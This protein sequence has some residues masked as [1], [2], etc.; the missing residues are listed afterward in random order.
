VIVTVVAMKLA[1]STV[2]AQSGPTCVQLAP[3]LDYARNLEGWMVK[4]LQSGRN[5]FVSVQSGLCSW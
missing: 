1:T 3:N 5:R 4:Q 2:A